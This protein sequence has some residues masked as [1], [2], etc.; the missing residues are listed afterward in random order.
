MKKKFFSAVFVIL[1]VFMIESAF[2]NVQASSNSFENVEETQIQDDSTTITSYSSSSSSGGQDTGG[3][4]WYNI[5]ESLPHAVDYSDSNL[6]KYIK[7]GDILYEATGFNGMTGHMAIVEGIFYDETYDQEYIRLIECGDAGVT[8]GLLTPTRFDNKEAEVYRLVDADK[9]QISEAIRFCQS[10]LGK[11]YGVALKKSSKAEKEKWYCSELI[12]AAYFRQ[13]IYLD[14]DDN[15]EDG[16]VVWPREII[17]YPKATLVLH[18]EYHT[19]CEVID[20][21]Q[22][23]LVCDDGIIIE[24]HVFDEEVSGY[25][26]KCSLCGFQDKI[27]KVEQNMFVSCHSDGESVNTYCEEGEYS[28]IHIYVECDKSYQFTST[29]LTKTRLPIQMYLY[30]D[31]MNLLN[32]SPEL[33]N[34]NMTGA[35]TQYLQKG[36]YHL[37]VSYPTNILSGEIET[38]CSATWLYYGSPLQDN[39]ETTIN[40]H[41][42]HTSDG[43]IENVVHYI[44]DLGAG[45]RQIML[46]VEREDGRTMIYPADCF[47]VKDYNDDEYLYKYNIGNLSKQATNAFNTNTLCVYLSGNGYSY[48]HI[49]LPDIKYRN[50]SITVTPLTERL[51]MNLSERMREDYIETV[52]SEDQIGDYA[53]MIIIDRLGSFKFLVRQIGLSNFNIDYVFF[54]QDYDKQT[55]QYS[56]TPLFLGNLN[57]TQISY[58]KTLILQPGTY[59]IAYFTNNPNVSIRATIER[60]CSTHLADRQ[61]IFDPGSGYECGSEVR[62]N[63]GKYLEKTI[64]EGF[65][66]CIYIDPSSLNTSTSRL[67]YLFYSSNEGI[68]TVSAYGTVLAKSVSSDQTVTVYAID[69]KYPQFVHSIT[70]TVLDDTSN[71]RREMHST[72]NHSY[73]YE[74]TNGEFKFSL[75]ESECPYTRFQDYVWDFEVTSG[76]ISFSM[77]NYGYINVSGPGTV[78][79]IG[80]YINNPNIY[81]YIT[82]Q[83]I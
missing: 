32:D 8:R 54:K 14:V 13:G 25:I 47:F 38:K 45:Y 4:K 62:M 72:V 78:V 42:H 20:Q 28:V 67:S 58:E 9:V 46:N 53:K 65:T 29:L 55:Y 57:G 27:Y 5:G 80:H 69:K 12:W 63:N 79:I 52:F 34:N 41:W 43:D 74:E 49:K 44:N 37:R 68:A 17:Q 30:D 26:Y 16:S 56:I 64:T 23:K 48:I 77:S 83:I 22:H 70:F 73:S 18:H 61:L 10:Q 50:I 82:I 11:A 33:S 81:V 2:K 39:V 3:E 36:V 59:Y 31:D 66:R 15:E 35:I 40:T 76:E 51:E 60:C 24:D 21:F 7:A 19:S 6:L 71:Q 1:F 75:K